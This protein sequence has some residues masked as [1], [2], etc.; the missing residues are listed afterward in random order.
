MAREVGRG[1]PFIPKRIFMIFDVP[2]NEVRGEHAHKEC[3]E[4]ERLQAARRHPGMNSPP[5]AI[6]VSIDKGE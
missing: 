1:L 4:L 5:L 3:H 6:D 2:S